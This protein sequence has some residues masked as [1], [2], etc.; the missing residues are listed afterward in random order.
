[1]K[2]R[3]NKGIFNLNSQT[4]K[5]KED[6]KLFDRLKE[7]LKQRNL[8]ILKNKQE[9]SQDAGNDKATSC[10]DISRVGLKELRDWPSPKENKINDFAPNNSTVSS[11]TI[12]MTAKYTQGMGLK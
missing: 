2:E 8:E 7:K 9:L 3:R 10:E 4:A 5:S 12:E 11:D 1:M 6:Q